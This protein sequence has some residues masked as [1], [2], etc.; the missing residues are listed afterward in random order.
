MKCEM[1]FD[2]ECY[3]LHIDGEWVESSVRFA[4]IKA[5]AEKAGFKVEVE[6]DKDGNPTGRP[7]CTYTE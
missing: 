1:G 6:L 4:D 2:G 7:V 5:T 3:H